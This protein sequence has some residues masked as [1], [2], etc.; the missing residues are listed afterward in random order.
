VAFKILDNLRVAVPGLNSE[1]GIPAANDTTD[2]SFGSTAERNAYLQNAFA[3]LWPRMGRLTRE[4]ITTVANQQ[5]YTL[6][7]VLD[8][9]R[10]EI[11]D[12]A[13][14]T[15]VADRVR[16]W[17]DYADEAADPYTLRLTVAAGMTAGL[18]L[19]VIGYVP[20]KIPASGGDTCDL[21][22]RLEHVVRAGARVEAYRAKINQFANFE[23]HQ[24]ENRQNALSAADV[25][26]LLRQSQR[27]FD[28]ALA[29]NARNLTGAH[30]A[31]LQT[32]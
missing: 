29:E 14:P 12:L 7:T 16:S 27:E 4:S 11:M 3:K 9:E 1:L 28:R 6:T 15:L 21:P 25:V 18:T 17:Q 26:E 20:Y 32:G 5:E 8:I 23:R 13:V 22:G 24:N 19:R 10:I 2:N 30:R 31:R